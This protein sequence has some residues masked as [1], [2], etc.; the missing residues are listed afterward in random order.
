M[1]ETV[2]VVTG[3]EPLDPDAVARLPR[4]GIVIAA[5]GALDH[6]LAAGLSPAGLV[7]DLDSISAG[8]LA[9]AEAHATIQRHDPDKDHTDTELALAIAADFNPARLV[10]VSG[11]GD[12]LDHTLAAIGA[13]GQSN[14]TSIPI[15]EAWWGNQHI[16]VLHG[17]GRLNF[18]VLPGTTISLVAMHGEC[19]GV[20]V[21]GVKWPLQAERLEPLAGRGI[22]NLA[23]D[24]QIEVT[25]FEGVV[26]IFTY[27]PEALS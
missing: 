27:A 22:S 11:G 15:V 5:D 7:G 12:R 2:I 4:N 24:E 13:L 25:V 9:W 14:L 3:A 8:G 1:D 23:T 6:A 19:N 10:M 16:R 20:T 18:D 26:T 21:T 17:P